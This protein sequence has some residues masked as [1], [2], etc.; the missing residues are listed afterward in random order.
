[1]ALLGVSSIIIELLVLS[2]YSAAVGL[3]GRMVRQPQFARMVRG[4]GGL[5]LMGAGVRLAAT[6]QS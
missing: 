2:A 3:T 6:D 4:F 1:V 5:L